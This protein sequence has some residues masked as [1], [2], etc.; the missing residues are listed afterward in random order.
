MLSKGKR[1]NF[2]DYTLLDFVRCEVFNCNDDPV[3]NNPRA[4]CR[5]VLYRE[6][7]V[8][9]EPWFQIE[10][11]NMLCTD[12]AMTQN[13][14]DEYYRACL[15]AGIKIYSVNSKMT[16][17][18]GPCVGIKIADDL[19]MARYLLY[20]IA[21]YFGVLVTF[22][23]AKM[24]VNISTKAMREEGGIQVIERAIDKLSRI[25]VDRPCV[26]FR[27]PL[28]VKSK[29]R[30]HFQ[31]RRPAAV[32]ADPYKLIENIIRTITFNKH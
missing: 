16:F 22:S 14:I 32:T 6:K 15:H 29:G 2:N 7:A 24:N 20:R 11:E 19:W 4:S 28:A 12:K 8:M 3:K 27:I 26:S 17:Q 31:D 25:Q 5:E 21:A 10:Q 18:I 13:I 30:G 23:N 1:N 9:E